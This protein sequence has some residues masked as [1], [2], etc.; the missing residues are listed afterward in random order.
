VG[1][2]FGDVMEVGDAGGGVEEAGGVPV[3]GEVVA[4]GAAVTNDHGEG[5]IGADVDFDAGGD[6]AAADGGSRE[7]VVE[8]SLGSADGVFDVIVDG[9]GVTKLL[10][11]AP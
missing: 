9:H 1:F 7:E 4:D 11:W 3:E 8:V 6:K 10:R 2:E 5:A